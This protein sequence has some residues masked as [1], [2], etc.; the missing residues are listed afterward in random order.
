MESPILQSRL[1]PCPPA[2]L[3]HYTT[4]PGLIGI[5]RQKEIW[6]THTQYLNDA[7]EYKY[8]LQIALDELWRM[9]NAAENED[10]KT[11]LGEMSD[12]LR[13][14]E[15]INVCV[16]SFSEVRD[17]LSQWRAYGESS[18]G[19]SIGFSGKF[20]KSLA[21]A[22]GC[23]LV[24][25]LYIRKAQIQLVRTL[26]ENVLKENLT[27][28]TTSLEDV[29][30]PGGNLQAYLHRYAPI[31]KDPSFSEER[32]WR[33]ISRPLMCSNRRFD[34][35]PGRSMLVPYFRFPLQ[36]QSINFE[37]QQV[38]VGPTPHKTEALQS[39]QSLLVSE[40]L[41]VPK[42]GTTDALVTAST[43]PYRAW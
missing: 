27:R 34:F 25:C 10:R 12:S 31:L 16:A 26:L 24:P 9:Y 22:E 5:I 13:G 20:L 14:I 17:S 11:H 43:V 39:V 7:T 36:S 35:R 40:K 19:F 29:S 30:P 32:E 37:I 1:H 41:H 2:T 33:L 4:Q 6:A 8:G 42:A 23:Y 18:A 38:V 15:S 28:A 21:D 3:Y